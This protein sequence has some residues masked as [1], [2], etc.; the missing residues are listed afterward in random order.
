MRGTRAAE[1]EREGRSV[2]GII[3]HGLDLDDA[4]FE[5]G[6]AMCRNSLP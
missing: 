2:A 4:R 1:C 5:R 3:A 6:V